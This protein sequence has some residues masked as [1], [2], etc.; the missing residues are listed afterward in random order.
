METWQ[1]ALVLTLAIGL[2]VLFYGAARDRRANRERARVATAPPSAPIPGFTPAAAPAYLTALQAR[3]PKPSPSPSEGEQRRIAEL[4]AVGTEVTCGWASSDFDNQDGQG[5]VRSRAVVLDA[6]VLVTDAAIED[7][8]CLITPLE[9]AIASGRGLVVVAS[10]LSAEVLGT[11]EVNALQGTVRV[12]A[13]LADAEQRQQVCAIAAAQPLS[14]SDL[15]A[16]YLPTLGRV[17]LWAAT[18]E[19]ST[20]AAGSPRAAQA[21]P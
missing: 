1:I 19:S 20:L 18:A 21:Q 5:A 15:A 16:G 9:R 12:L 8:R 11:L 13:V 3:R 6:D 10:S 7:F 14:Y 2:A 17:A 4:L